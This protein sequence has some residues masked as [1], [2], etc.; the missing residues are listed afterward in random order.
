M[1]TVKTGDNMAG[2][3]KVFGGLTTSQNGKQTRSIVA[4]NSIK[5]VAKL[6]GLSQ[7]FIRGWWSITANKEERELALNKPHTVI[8]IK[9]Y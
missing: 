9:E 4:A 8:Y 6:T 5:E 7:Y 3:L 1:V 2:E